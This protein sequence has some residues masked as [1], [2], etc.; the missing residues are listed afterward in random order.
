MCAGRAFTKDFIV[1]NAQILSNEAFKCL[2]EIFFQH[3]K[4][5]KGSDEKQ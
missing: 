2:I 5:K 1:W 4:E 3:L